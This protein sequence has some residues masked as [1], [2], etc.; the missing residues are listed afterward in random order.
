MACFGALECLITSPHVGKLGSQTRALVGNKCGGLKGTLSGHFS[1]MIPH[2]LCSR[3]C[4]CSAGRSVSQCSV[5]GEWEEPVRGE[6]YLFFSRSLLGRLLLAGGCLGMVHTMAAIV[7]RTPYRMVFGGPAERALGFVA[8]ID[9]ASSSSSWMWHS[10]FVSLASLC[11]SAMFPRHSIYPSQLVATCGYLFVAI[12]PSPSP[13]APSFSYPPPFPPLPAG[14]S[15]YALLARNPGASRHSQPHS[16]AG[17]KSVNL[18]SP[19][20][21]ATP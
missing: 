8:I 7:W 17:R 15:Y 12:T 16:Q 18:F 6:P 1:R 14:F 2:A 5:P 11:H 3:L 20:E 19:Y 10:R 9:I 21:K 4:V 13:L